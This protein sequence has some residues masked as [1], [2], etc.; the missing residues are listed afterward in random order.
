MRVALIV[1]KI[2]TARRLGLRYC[3]MCK[4]VSFLV[5]QLEKIVRTDSGSWHS[6]NL[7]TCRP[8]KSH[9]VGLVTALNPNVIVEVGCGIGDIISNIRAHSKYGIDP[10][11]GAIKLAKILHP[12]SGV[13]WTTG[14]LN[15]LKEVPGEIDALILIG[16][17]HYISPEFLEQVL[18]SQLSR[19]RYL[20]LDQFNDEMALPW[21]D[22]HPPYKHNFS[23]L[24]KYAECISVTT[25]EDDPV[26]RY[27]VYRVLEY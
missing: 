2:Q 4:A 8:Y 14:D 26:R 25:P 3:I 24:Q 11:A 9:V 5:R 12:F 13:K 16:M 15:N 27:L 7:Y 10:D 21:S 18:L 6:D 17:L 23:F 1:R 20:I 22:D 19:I